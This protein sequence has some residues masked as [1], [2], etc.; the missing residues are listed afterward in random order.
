MAFFGTFHTDE[1]KTAK[2]SL[3]W[4]EILLT[5]KLFSQLTFIIYYSIIIMAITFKAQQPSVNS[6]VCIAKVCIAD[7]YLLTMLGHQWIYFAI[8]LDNSK[9]PQLFTL[10]AFLH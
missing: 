8:T 6:K 1:A 5:T 7:G 4:D 2:V 3:H 10:W 9:L